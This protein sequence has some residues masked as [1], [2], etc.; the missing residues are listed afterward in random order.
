MSARTLK[1]RSEQNGTYSKKYLTRMRFVLPQDLMMTD[2]GNS[3][4]SLKT[5]LKYS[6]GVI[7]NTK[8][9]EEADGEAGEFFYSFGDGTQPYSASCLFRTAKLFSQLSGAVIEEINYSNYK[10]ANFEALTH[11]IDTFAAATSFSGACLSTQVIDNIQPNYSIW[12][13]GSE[14]ELHIRLKDLFPSLNT[15][16]Y[17][18]KQS[19]LIV[20]L[21]L[22]VTKDLIMKIRDNDLVFEPPSTTTI[23]GKGYVSEST[24][25]TSCL[26]EAQLNFLF[27][28][29]QSPLKVIRPP[30]WVYLASEYGSEVIY[31]DRD[32]NGDV[33]AVD[34]FKVTQNWTDTD[35][36]NLGFT[37]GIPMHI[38]QKI[39]K[40]NGDL[41]QTFQHFTTFKERVDDG[42]LNTD[43]V[44]NNYTKAVRNT[45][46][47][48]QQV[49][50][51]QFNPLT[52]NKLGSAG[53]LL[54]PSGT[55]F[56]AFERLRDEK[57]YRLS[58]ADRTA[59]L[60]AGVL[61]VNMLTGVYSLV[62]GISFRVS[63]RIA[64]I[65]GEGQD[66]I[67]VASDR[68]DYEADDNVVY[69]VSNNANFMPRVT[70]AR[71]TLVSYDN[72]EREI[73]FSSDFELGGVGALAP[74]GFF[75]IDT[76]GAVEPALNMA[77]TI[78]EISDVASDRLA[79]NVV[80]GAYP[81]VSKAEIVLKQYPSVANM[82]MPTIYRTMRV[83][84]F[85]I[86][87]GFS[88]YVANFQIEG[89]CYNAY[90]LLPPAS[91]SDSLM[92]TGR[93]V[94]SWR[95][96]IDEVDLTNVDVRMSGDYPSS[97][98]FDRLVDTFSNSQMQIRSLAG[99]ATGSLQGTKAGKVR[100]VPIKIY[101]GMVNG[102]PI[103][104]PTMKRLQVR[105]Q[106]ESG[107]VIEG[108]T[109]Y[110]FKEVYRFY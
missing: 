82:K 81:E 47:L 93:N 3:Y 94:G 34:V 22:E 75:H 110:L 18:L 52:K 49:R 106:A 41:V 79:G 16:V 64:R 17:S 43:M 98:Y 87:S 28:G 108:G 48:N 80:V 97:L 21:E 99:I 70:P 83:E 55:D 91:G 103:L 105:L 69:I 78:T 14:Q 58:V 15:A 59:L 35:T 37:V 2:A 62:S 1:I 44:M 73:E 53:V 84:P 33:V 7:I 10:T 104:S 107:G 24:T 26:V 54:D 40:D 92:S 95:S 88:E 77:L 9:S 29:V 46:L 38:I 51:E 50:L 101:S 56:T 57:K 100:L 76:A 11:D 72:A 36:D 8:E 96:T 45:Y 109:A 6:D 19:P 39:K 86:T 25:P 102:Q 85:N 12:A 20:D 42:S 32:G 66:V 60:A 90:L 65:N 67:I 31:G 74:L 4:L 61:S 89:N 23:G 27:K 30:E 71:M 13:Q 68:S 5:V 63:L